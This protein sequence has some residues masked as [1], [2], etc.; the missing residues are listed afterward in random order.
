LSAAATSSTAAST[1]LTTLASGR[2]GTATGST[3]GAGG[4]TA[5]LPRR[6]LNGNYHLHKNE[7]GKN[8]CQS[9]D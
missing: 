4:R 6:G 1:T 8:R 7:N 3:S 5:L 2:C 9:N